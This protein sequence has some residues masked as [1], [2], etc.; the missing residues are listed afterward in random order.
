[1]K[2]N[3]IVFF[4]LISSLNAIAQKPILLDDIHYYVSDSSVR[5]VANNYFKT[6]FKGRAM[7]EQ[8]MN[9]LSFIDFISIRPDE[10]T[11]NISSPGPFPGV[12]VGDPKRW[13]R[14]KIK[15]SASNPPMYGV[16][17][18]ALNTKNIRKTV[19]K[20]LKAG[21]DFLMEDFTLPTEPDVNAVA[22]YGF[23]YNIIVLV[24]RPKMKKQKTEFGIDHLQLLVK[25][26]EDNVKFYQTVLAAEIIDK[27]ERSTVLKIGNHK[28]VLSEPEAL[29]LV[30]EQVV[31][32]DPK[33]FVANIDHLGFLYD[34]IEPAFYGAKANNYRVI[35]EPKTL[36]Y[37]DKPTPY[38]FCILM[39]P[40]NLQIELE[41]EDGRTT[42]RKI[43][44]NEK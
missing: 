32:R 26:L 43:Y 12:K 15:P 11:I 33:K 22:M 21:Y 23:D 38:T 1:M 8:E 30:R 44:K 17:W 19:K 37:Y 42:A 20:L 2:R 29:G 40:D 35:M 10:S 16:R 24:E 41:Q 5:E 3:F 4:L 6:F 14:E 25:N 18:V 36:M 28:F 27:K 7:A 13:F 31:E 9:P 34:E 39:S